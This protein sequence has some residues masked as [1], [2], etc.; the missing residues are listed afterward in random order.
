MNV[1]L[2]YSP[3]C[4]DCGRAREQMDRAPA[5]WRALDVLEHLE[6]AVALG[7]RRTPALVVDGRVRAVGPD[8]AR[9]LAHLLSGR[10]K[11]R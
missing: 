1:R 3:Y 2:F 6:E 11:A 9:E 5:G 7:I 4:P 8:A 10:E